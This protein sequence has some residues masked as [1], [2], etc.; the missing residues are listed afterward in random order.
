MNMQIQE[1][2]KREVDRA[3]ST[4][5]DANVRYHQVLRRFLRGNSAKAEARLD[6]A[7]LKEIDSSWIKLNDANKNLRRAYMKLYSACI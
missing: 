2:A 6:S 7:G 3:I 1:A 5:E 4:D